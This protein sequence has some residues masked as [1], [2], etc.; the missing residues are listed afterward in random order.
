[1]GKVLLLSFRLDN[2]SWKTVAEGR[3]DNKKG[4]EQECRGVGVRGAE[5]PSSN[6]LRLDKLLT[7]PIYQRREKQ[8]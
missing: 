4:T 7:M 5:P 6:M 1:M 2:S 8:R 3:E